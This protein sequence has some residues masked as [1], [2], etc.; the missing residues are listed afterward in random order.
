MTHNRGDFVVVDSILRMTKLSLEAVGLWF[1]PQA[2][3]A[4]GAVLLVM[5]ATLALSLAESDQPPAPAFLLHC[6]K[7][8]VALRG[9]RSQGAGMC[10]EDWHLLKTQALPG[11]VSVALSLCSSSHALA[12]S[13]PGAATIQS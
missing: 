9:M 3:S 2:G 12:L 4:V 10:G 5:V 11:S 6:R 8:G 13:A 7:R 1:K